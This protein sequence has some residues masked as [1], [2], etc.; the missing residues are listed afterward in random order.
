M[1]KLREDIL[2]TQNRINKNIKQNS[3]RNYAE[4]GFGDPDTR[5]PPQ[6]LV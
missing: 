1:I 6:A 5:I 4:N 3:A 2:L